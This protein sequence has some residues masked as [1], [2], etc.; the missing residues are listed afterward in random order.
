[1]SVTL[2]RARVLQA[3]GQPS[4]LAD[5]EI[6]AGVIT[7]VR[8]SAAAHQRAQSHPRDR[9]DHE[10]VDLDGRWLIPGLWDAHVHMVQ[11]ALVRRRLDVSGAGSARE[12]A[13]LVRARIAVD[14]PVAG[15]MLVGFGFRDATWP[16]APTLELLDRAAG[17]HAVALVSGDL[18]CGW[19]S[20]AALRR[21]GV[22]SDASGLLREREF[23]PRMG[24]FDGGTPAERDAWVRE[25][26]QAAA[27]RGV[28]GIVD[29]EVADIAADWTRRLADSRADLET[30]PPGTLRIRTGV[31]PQYLD[32][33]LARGIRGGEPLPGVMRDAAGTPLGHVGPLKVISDGSLNTRTALCHEPYLDADGAA[34][35]L[36]GAANLTSEELTDVMRRARAAGMPCASHGIG[37]RAITRALYSFD[38]SSASGTI[39]H[40]QLLTAADV[41]RFA[42]LGITAS[43]QPQHL[44][45]DR[46]VADQLWADRTSRAYPFAD[47][48]AA[49]VRLALGSDA[50][51]A[52]LD[53][54]QAIAAAV[55]RT[56]DAQPPWHPEQR[57]DAWAALAASTDGAGVS[58]AVGRVADLAVL[59][60]DPLA[61]SRD[62][63]VAGTLLAGEWTHRG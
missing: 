27:A 6:A 48:L 47:L 49:G 2:R 55:T 40:A 61:A 59:E 43:V 57:I 62:V 24:E 60:T 45:D 10:V 4:V 20:S 23:L 14:P 8:P 29:F 58:P 5:V 18:H 22:T 53:P 42:A 28:V 15:A 44:I 51:V 56:G 50:P 13:D 11:W 12:V 41:R 17:G 37:D 21:L 63:A 26:A 39:E 38:S 52:R 9:S 7:G 19:F 34:S 31:W 25:A 16:D 30:P 36:W 54:W 33:V 1:M 3:P 46:A 35:D 32:E